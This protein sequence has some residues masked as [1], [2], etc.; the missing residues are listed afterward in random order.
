MLFKRWWGVVL[1]VGNQFS[2]SA[3]WVHRPLI[4]RLVVLQ[5]SLT[6]FIFW[7][8]CMKFD[9]WASFLGAFKVFFLS[10]YSESPSRVWLFATPW[11]G[12]YQ[13][14]PSM[15]FP[16]QEYWSGLPFP[17]SGSSRPRD[18]THVRVPPALQAVLYLLSYQ[19][20]PLFVWNALKFHNAVS[21]FGTVM[22]SSFE[23]DS[24][25]FFQKR[26]LIFFNSG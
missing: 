21:W 2:S 20:C 13:A 5:L 26:K 11:T 9:F 10:R 15:G 4:F 16:R 6:S 22:F 12:V 7:I 1:P 18:R 19:G 23:L 24:Q 14:P 17:P 8:F 3:F 25:R